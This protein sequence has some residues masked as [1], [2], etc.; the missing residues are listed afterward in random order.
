M[1]S[2]LRSAT[3]IVSFSSESQSRLAH[4]IPRRPLTVLCLCVFIWARPNSTLSVKYG[5]VS[6]RPFP[7]K[8][9]FL[10]HFFPFLYILFVVSKR[11]CLSS[12]NKSA[13][14]VWLFPWNQTKDVL[15]GPGGLAA[16]VPCCF[17]F[18]CSQ[19]LERELGRCIPGRYK[20]KYRFPL[21]VP[22]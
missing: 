4:T 21:H 19:A 7:Q 22:S 17:F 12:S 6:L 14:I 13:Q 20:S 10:F 15:V 1:A 18:C 3:S 16:N 9:C 11:L 8:D 2:L 5:S